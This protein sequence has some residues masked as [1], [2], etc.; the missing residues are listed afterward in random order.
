LKNVLGVEVLPAG[1]LA[2][3]GEGLK[4]AIH[5]FEQAK[6][7]DELNER[8]PPTGENTDCL[9]NVLAIHAVSQSELDAGKGSNLN[10]NAGSNANSR[11]STPGI[12]TPAPIFKVE[13]C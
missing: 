7:A 2:L 10:S 3:G 4:K 9:K 8:L 11:P 13:D 12:S 1:T 5:G 6:K